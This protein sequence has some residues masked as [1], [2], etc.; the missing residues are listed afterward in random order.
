MGKVTSKDG[1]S[2]AYDRTGDGAPVILVDGAFGNRGFGENGLAALLA[3]QQDNEATT[4][5]SGMAPHFSVIVYDRRGRNDSGDTPPYAIQREIEDIQALVDTVG[6]S[7]YVYGISSGAVLAA[8]AAAALPGITK[9]ALYEPPLVLDDSRPPV[10][11]DYLDK[12]KAMIATGRRGDAVKYFMGTGVGVPAIFVFMMQFMPAW[13]TLKAV[14]HTVVYDTT[15]MGDFTLSPA[16]SK[17]A[18]SIKVPAL[19]MGGGK[20]PSWLN[21]AARAVSEAIPGAGLRMLDGQTHQVDPKVI[22]PVL[23]E[24]FKQ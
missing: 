15:I 4:I 22:G 12:L 20:S 3:R 1:T 6:G 21:H 23:I 5:S 17:A 11:A 18:A 9:L 24:F 2:I 14:A 19:V 10:P 13:K 7:A 16:L 8:Y